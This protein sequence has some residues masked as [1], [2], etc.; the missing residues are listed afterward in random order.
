[1]RSARRAVRI[2]SNRVAKTTVARSA[3]GWSDL[4]DS[5]L[6]RDLRVLATRLAGLPPRIIRPRVEADLVHVVEVGEVSNI[7]YVPGLQQL[8]ARITAV[9]KGEATV[10]AA[11]R[12]VT[13]GALDA[14]AAALRSQPHFISGITYRFR[15]EVMIDPLAVV[16]GG[17]VII[18]DIA[19]GEGTGDIE[20]MEEIKR[21]ELVGAL[22]DALEMSAEVAHRGFRHLPPTFFSRIDRTASALRIVGLRRAAESMA[23]L[24]GVLQSGRPDSATSVWIDTQI[25]LMV[26]AESL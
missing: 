14:L 5:I 3:G 8:T 12:G 4:P 6:V 2:A 17:S 13:P 21:D 10:V 1:M 19:A 7:S 23:R 25:R 20:A 24:G 16:A 26:T 22:D 18:P 15:G 9:D 11:H